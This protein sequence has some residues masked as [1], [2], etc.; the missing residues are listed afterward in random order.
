MSECEWTNGCSCQRTFP[1]L[2]SAEP[3][4]LITIITIIIISVLLSK[5]TLRQ[6][7]QQTDRQTH[8]H[9]DTF[10]HTPGPKKT[11]KARKEKDGQGMHG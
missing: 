2:V 1:K 10:R 7:D 4:S 8:T 3:P 11:K 5:I 9:R 6:T